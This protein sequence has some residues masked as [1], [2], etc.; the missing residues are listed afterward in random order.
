LYSC[1][2]SLFCTTDGS[3]EEEE[4]EEEDEEQTARSH[5]DGEEKDAGLYD[6]NGK[7]VVK[8]GQMVGEVRV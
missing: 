5:Q 7:F 8:L 4:E 2:S 1:S 3:P 6:E